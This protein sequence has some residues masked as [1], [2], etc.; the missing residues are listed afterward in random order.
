[1]WA[2]NC[3]LLASFCYLKNATLL[4]QT[5][6]EITE[7]LTLI[8]RAKTLPEV[9]GFLYEKYY[10]AIYLFVNKRV[11]EEMITADLVSQV[12]L[13]ALDNLKK[14]TFKGVPFSAWLYRIATNQVNEFYRKN[15][16]QR[17]V[18]LEP[19]HVSHLID[20]FDSH[21][22]D[23]A[24]LIGKLLEPLSDE[25]VQML[26]LRF[27]EDRSFHEVAYILDITETNAK[28]KVHRLLKKLKKILQ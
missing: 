22:L 7:E 11:G 19:T 6:K 8:E 16:K 18:S 3:N 26:E 17:V 13:K 23:P 10:E 24:E 12:F 27:F 25:E 20:E 4:H 14:Y 5:E 9:F 2:K 28:V 15:Q 21:G 1:M